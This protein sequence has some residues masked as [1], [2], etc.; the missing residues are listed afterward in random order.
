MLVVASTHAEP[1]KVISTWPT[2]RST[3]HA[4]SI[5]KNVSLLDAN[6]LKVARLSQ[7]RTSCCIQ[8]ESEIMH[9]LRI[10]SASRKCNLVSVPAVCMDV[11]TNALGN[12]PRSSA[13]KA[14]RYTDLLEGIQSNQSLNLKNS[15]P[16]LS[17]SGPLTLIHP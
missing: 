2:L 15:A 8:A 5:I 4:R 7:H 10:C 17:V 13:S 11:A 6:K 14:G 3:L 12:A 1:R 9:Y 16:Q